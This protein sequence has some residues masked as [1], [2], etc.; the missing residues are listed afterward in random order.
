MWVINAE[1]LIKTLDIESFLSWFESAILLQ[2]LPNSLVQQQDVK[3]FKS[4]LQSI[5]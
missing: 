4:T 1:G 2:F 3:S 5:P